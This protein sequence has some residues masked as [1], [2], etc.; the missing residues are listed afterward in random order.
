[1]SPHYLNI[2]Q[3]LWYLFILML[4]AGHKLLMLIGNCF[5]NV[6]VTVFTMAHGG[7]QFGLQMQLLLLEC[8]D[9]FFT[10]KITFI[11]PHQLLCTYTM[12]SFI[13]KL[14]NYSEEI[15]NIIEY[16]LLSYQHLSNKIGTTG[17]FSYYK[18]SI[19]NERNVIN[20]QYNRIAI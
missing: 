1:M 9:I 7:L 12:K 5:R 3:K 14:W 10:L 18:M 4:H 11:Q 15:S 2:A 20:I 17:T 8:R 16:L 6:R 19:I 13:K